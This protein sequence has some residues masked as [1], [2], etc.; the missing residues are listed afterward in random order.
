MTYKLTIPTLKDAL[1]APWRVRNEI[2]RLLVLPAARL[3]FFLA[4]VQ[5]GHGWR[6]YGMPM[7]QIHRDGRISIGDYLELRSNR[8]SNPLVPYHPV[9][10]SV[11]EPGA[12]LSIG[13]NFKMTGGA[14]IAA[15]RVQIGHNVNVGANTII[16][17]TDFHPVDPKL[18]A[19]NFS[20]GA[21]APIMIDDWAFIGTEVMVMKGAHIGAHSVIGARSVVTGNI[22]PRVV[23]AGIPARVIR[24]LEPE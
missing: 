13:D 1:R 16:V 8:A 23:A 6:I 19:A 24:E 20:A 17:D 18:R 15:E 12:V 2:T 5:W 21:S 11:R 22:P 3:K 10:L 14:V 4:G 7:L 9:M